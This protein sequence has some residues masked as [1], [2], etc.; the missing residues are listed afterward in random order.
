[1]LFMQR[2]SWRDIL[3]RG[4]GQ[5]VWRFGVVCFGGI[6]FLTNT[7]IRWLSN[8]PDQRYDLG[9]TVTLLIISFVY[10]LSVGAAFGLLSWFGITAVHR[11]VRRKQSRAAEVFTRPLDHAE[12]HVTH[13][14]ADRDALAQS[15][16]ANK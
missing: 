13:S 16:T 1:M 12:V 3:E 10:S 11:L 4:M 8:N 9:I 5:F 14:L 7:P 15:A 2:G 6:F